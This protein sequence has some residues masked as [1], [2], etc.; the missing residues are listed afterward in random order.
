VSG[1]DQLKAARV[2]AEQLRVARV[3]GGEELVSSWR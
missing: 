2:G 3:G 1:M